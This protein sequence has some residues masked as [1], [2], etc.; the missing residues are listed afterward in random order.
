MDINRI[1]KQ[2]IKYKPQRRRNI[3]H[4]KKSWKEQLHLEV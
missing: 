3:G 2:A 1:P 4:P